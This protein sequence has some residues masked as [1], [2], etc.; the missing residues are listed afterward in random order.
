MTA[1]HL[2][3]QPISPDS[4]AS[5]TT[6]H[7]IKRQP[8]Q[9]GTSFAFD[10]LKLASGTTIAQLLGILASPILT[11]FYAPDAFGILAV[12]TSITS[13]IG[14]IACLR[15]ELA[16]ML[17]ESDEEAANLLGVSLMFAVLI[18]LLI[19]PIV[20][21]GGDILAGWLNAPNLTPYLWLAPLAVLF[22]GVFMALNYW[23]SRTKRFGRLSIARVAASVSTTTA[24]LGAGFAGFANGGVLIGASVGG[25]IL[26]TSVLAGQIWRD[27]RKMFLGSIRWRE[28]IQGIKRYRKFPLYDIWSALLN[29]ISWQLPAFLLSAFFSSTVVGYYA[30]GFRI[31]QLPMSLIGQSIGQVFF[32]R[33]S[34][35]NLQG[36]LAPLV[37]AIFRRLVMIGIFPMF[38]LAIIGRDLY[39]VVFGANWAEAGVYT[40]ILAVWAFFWFISSPLSTLFSVLQR[41]EQGLNLN[42]VIFFSR[43]G[44][45]G[46]GGYLGNARLSLVLFAVTGTLVYGYLDY[47]VMKASGVP[48]LRA[49]R[50]IG[51][52]I[53]YS[54]PLLIIVLLLTIIGSQ[55]WIILL[56]I[57][58]SFGLYIFVVRKLQ[59]DLFHVVT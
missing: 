37:E 16:I 53:A 58:V 54:A 38:M 49:F 43:L 24:Q 21:W 34:K 22:S 41:Q 44:A 1:R 36:D 9:P 19:V 50:I 6:D 42:L 26:A 57:P 8:V 39:A 10:V 35:A 30:L 55:A 27:D 51:S 33:A 45:L 23:N 29:T 14:V 12:F 31:L 3:E 18:S 17:P 59:P 56:S 25:N 7:P 46:V 11:R 47:W 52:A 32:Q 5:S 28:M 20:W 13:I 48:L 4:V 15:Y 2:V 40:Q